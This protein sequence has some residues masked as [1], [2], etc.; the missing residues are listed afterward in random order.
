MTT[1]R[2]TIQPEEEA[3]LSEGLSLDQISGAL[4]KA[5]KRLEWLEEMRAAKVLDERPCN[6]HN[7][8]LG[9]CYICTGDEELDRQIKRQRRKIQFLK[10]LYSQAAD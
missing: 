7:I 2:V 4:R 6:R 5:K 9:Q 10:Y 1:Y 8:A 3:P